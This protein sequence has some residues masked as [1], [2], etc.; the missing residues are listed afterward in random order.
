MLRKNNWKYNRKKSSQSY[1]F[2]SSQFF[3]HLKC[4][5]I[6]FFLKLKFY[7]QSLRLID[8]FQFFSAVLRSYKSANEKSNFYLI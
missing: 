2:L 6:D 4:Y 1:Y 8:K 5:F 7:G 3:F